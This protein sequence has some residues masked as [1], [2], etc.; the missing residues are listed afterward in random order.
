MSKL[1]GLSISFCVRDICEG[2]VSFDDVSF[3]IPGM[4][5][6]ENNT[7]WDVYER[8]KQSYWS[9]FPEQS[10]LVLERIEIRSHPGNR[11]NISAGCW[12]LEE[13]YNETLDLRHSEHL[14]FHNLKDIKS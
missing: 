2:R 3:I 14:K 9:K 12:M 11:P 8:Y 1:I 13:D 5:L 10:R 4:D 7:I 6:N